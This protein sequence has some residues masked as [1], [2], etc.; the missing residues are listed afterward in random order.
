MSV[1]LKPERTQAADPVLGRLAQFVSG[2]SGWRTRC[3]AWVSG[4]IGALSLAPLN[5][6]PALVVTCVAS[7]W[8][9]DGISASLKTNS[10]AGLWAAMQVGWWVGFGYFVAGLWW[11]GAAFLVDAEDFAW[12]LP[13]GVAGLP[14]VL[15][16]FTALG[17]AGALLLWSIGASRILA[18]ALALAASEWLRAT[19]LTGFPWNAFGMAM[20]NHLNLAQAASL[21]GLHGLT[22]LTLLVCASPATLA[23]S[24]PA[25]AR[26]LAPFLGLALVAALAAFGSVRL[27]LH[28][29]TFDASVK[30]RIVQPNTPQ[31]EDFRADR[32]D[33][34]LSHYL[35]GSAVATARFPTGL[36]EVTHL[37]WP[38]SAFPF[39]LARD[40]RALAAIGRALGDT[41]LV[42]GAARMETSNDDRLPGEIR[43]VS[44]FNAIQVVGGH[45]GQ[46][47]DSYDKVHLVPFGEYLPFSG[48]LESLG[49]RQFVHIP[50]GFEPGL[51]RKLITVPGLPAIFPLI[52]YEAIFPGT[53]DPD[54]R[55][56]AGLIVNVSNDG[57][58]GRTAGPYQHLAQARLR[59]IE[60]GL[61]VLRAANT[62]MSAV[63][64][65][66]GRLIGTLGL[67]VEGVLDT[68]LPQQAAAPLFARAP[69][70]APLG[71]VVLLVAM[72]LWA[73]RRSF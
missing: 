55:R 25:R 19:A 65:P 52:C 44:Y 35:K 11:L 24:G 33:E 64:D 66:Y 10:R 40:A 20:G 18:F 45:D 15:A 58:F 62:G 59:S 1:T 70:L 42:S 50:G 36:A 46:I 48:W 43:K 37:V 3:L 32:R 56:H 39:F 13:L 12:A 6:L 17:F 22:V 9:L 8:L 47:L 5:L 68:S 73:R 7:V 53:L 2:A 69:V 4:A 54:L 14:A 63:I 23:L 72:F 67:G 29:T 57:W 27:W 21:V 49:L 51:T 41:I 28:P 30:L 16:C 61:P 26:L 31:D 38:E 71:L 34:I 60:L